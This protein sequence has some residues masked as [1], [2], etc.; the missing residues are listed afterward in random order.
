ML[1]REQTEILRAELVSE[2]KRLTESAQ[3]ALS[4]TMD[5][6][7]DR[8]GRDSLDESSEEALYATKL[9]LHDREKYLLVKI[10]A[11]LRRLELGEYGACE[12][13]EEPIGFERL[14]A[15]PV[16]SLCIQ[17]KSDREQAEGG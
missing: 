17:C 5:R 7:R 11:A 4:F 3:S 9:R 15:R 14:R 2:R 12:D 6:D 16:T 8:I 13:C 1:S 10:E